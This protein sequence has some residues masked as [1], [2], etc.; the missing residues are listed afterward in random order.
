MASFKFPPKYGVGLCGIKATL[1][2]DSREFQDICSNPDVLLL[3]ARGRRNVCSA[4]PSLDGYVI[5]HVFCLCW[6]VAPCLPCRCCDACTS[7]PVHLQGKYAPPP[8]AYTHEWGFGVCL[9]GAHGGWHH[10]ALQV[11]RHRLSSMPRAASD[12]PPW[13]CS[14]PW[15]AKFF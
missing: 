8:H 12:K 7:Q 1:Y 5:D 9:P 14:W 15:R 4:T 11:V 6:R 13:T 3:S 10:G 2:F